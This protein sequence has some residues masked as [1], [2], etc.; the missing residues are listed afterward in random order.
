MARRV[1]ETGAITPVATTL[2]R[3]IAGGRLTPGAR[4]EYWLPR[5]VA[6]QTHPLCGTRLDATFPYERRRG[7]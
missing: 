2:E 3:T 4:A 6:L 7:R 5:M 1:R